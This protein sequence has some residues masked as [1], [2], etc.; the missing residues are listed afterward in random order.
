MLGAAED[1][2]RLAPGLLDAV[3]GGL[4]AFR[5]QIAYR[6]DVGELQTQHFMHEAG[7]APAAADE[8]HANPFQRIGRQVVNGLLALG[9]GPGY[10][11]S[12]LEH[13]AAGQRH[14]PGFV[15]IRIGG[16]SVGKDGQRRRGAGDG[17]GFQKVTA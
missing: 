6:D 2:G 10:A 1:L 15:G 3:G 17:G 16:A 11:E 4:G 14:G 9:T 5:A 8:S 12:G 13:N 7:P